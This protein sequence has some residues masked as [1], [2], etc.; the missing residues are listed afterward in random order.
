MINFY[1]KNNMKFIW[2]F[3]SHEFRVIFSQRLISLILGENVKQSPLQNYS[4]WWYMYLLKNIHFYFTSISNAFNECFIM[5]YDFKSDTYNSAVFKEFFHTK[6]WV[7]NF[8]LSFVQSQVQDP[9]WPLHNTL[10]WLHKDDAIQSGTCSYTWV[11]QLNSGVIHLVYWN[12]ALE[13]RFQSFFQ[14]ELLGLCSHTK[15]GPRRH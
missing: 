1:I 6:V 2:K 5:K 9:H 10:Y 4:K 13:N 7:V 11:E 15:E 12:T 8:I 3:N 14:L